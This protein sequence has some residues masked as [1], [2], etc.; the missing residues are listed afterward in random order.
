MLAGKAGYCDCFRNTIVAHEMMLPFLFG[1]FVIAE[2][3][4]YRAFCGQRL[5]SKRTAMGAS[6]QVTA[7]TRTTAA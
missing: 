1:S 6:A 2:P 3:S 4:G 5:S 7:A